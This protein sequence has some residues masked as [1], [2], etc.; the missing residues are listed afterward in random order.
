MEPRKDGLFHPAQEG[1]DISAAGWSH[2]WRLGSDPEADAKLQ[3]LV[4]HHG[5][6]HR[7][8]YWSGL[9]EESTHAGIALQSGEN[10]LDLV[11]D[12]GGPPPEVL[13]TFR[14]G[15]VIS[16]HTTGQADGIGI[17]VDRTRTIVRLS[18]HDNFVQARECVVYINRPTPPI[19]P[20]EQ[21]LD[22]D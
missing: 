1:A 22:Q 17:D 16:V 21:P 20:A 15:G 6:V 4:F 5:F 9:F 7:M 19:R 2:S 12:V 14:F 18:D 3:T 13:V 8:E 10:I 11:I